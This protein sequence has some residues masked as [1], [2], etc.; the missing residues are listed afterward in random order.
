MDKFN[1]IPI[2]DKMNNLREFLLPRAKKI[3]GFSFSVRFPSYDGDKEIVPVVSALFS[4]IVKSFNVLTK[5][6][7][8]KD[9]LKKTRKACNVFDEYCIEHKLN[10]DFVCLTTFK[11][12]S[13]AEFVVS[14]KSGNILAKEVKK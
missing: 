6:I 3:K 2:A 8:N 10:T 5:D 13:R 7:E 12:D 9:E 1:Y 14:N 11:D 4:E